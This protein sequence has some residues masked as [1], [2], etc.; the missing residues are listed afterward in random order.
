MLAGDRDTEQLAVVGA[1]EASLKRKKSSTLTRDADPPPPLPTIAVKPQVPAKP[2]HIRPG[3]KPVKIPTVDDK[4]W[5]WIA[6]RAHVCM[7]G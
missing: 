3:L 1:A 5:V 6:N 4:V 2:A 7:M